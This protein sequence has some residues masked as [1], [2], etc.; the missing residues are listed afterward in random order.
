MKKI[1]I[2]LGLVLIIFNLVGC[3][4]NIDKKGEELNTNNIEA[5]NINYVK[6]T[7]ER[8]GFSIEYPDYLEVLLDPD[9]GDGIKVGDKDLRLTVSGSYNVLNETPESMEEEIVK[10]KSNISYKE[11]GKDFFVA[12]WLEG[13]KVIYEYRKVGKNMIQGFI[14]EYNESKIKEFEPIVNKIYKSFKA[15]EDI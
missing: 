2:K 7:N 3:G 6:Y 8:F 10:T 12:S 4:A 13:D 11:K 1:F 15:S 5:K 9:N 14:L